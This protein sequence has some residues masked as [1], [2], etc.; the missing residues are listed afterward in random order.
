MSQSRRDFL[1]LSAA[2]MAILS[3]GVRAFGSPAAPMGEIDVRLTAGAAKFAP[4]AAIKWLAAGGISGDTIVL[5][6]TKTYQ[7][8]LGVG[9][10]SPRG[11]VICSTS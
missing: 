8:V 10:A 5:D 9:A 3:Q 4:Q 6:P 2:G 7:E 11:P 1:K